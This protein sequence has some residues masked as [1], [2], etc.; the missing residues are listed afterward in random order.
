MVRVKIQWGR[1]VYKGEWLV[2]ASWRHCGEK[3]REDWW[4]LIQAWM[5]SRYTQKTSQEKRSWHKWLKASTQKFKQVRVDRKSLVTNHTDSRN[6]Q[7][8]TRCPSAGFR[9]SV[10]RRWAAG[11]QRRGVETERGGEKLVRAGTLLTFSLKTFFNF[12]EMAWY[13]IVYTFRHGSSF[14]VSWH[15]IVKSDLNPSSSSSSFIFF[16]VV[17]IAAC[18]CW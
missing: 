1:W 4:V 17:I 3:S 13:S 9:G 16:T 2:G 14:C 6:P 10:M 12:K 7:T 15:R 8:L 11:V 18:Q 5:S